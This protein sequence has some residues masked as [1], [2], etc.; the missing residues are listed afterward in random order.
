[1]L[2]YFTLLYSLSLNG[3]KTDSSSKYALLNS[4][5]SKLVNGTYDDV[6]IVISTGCSGY[7]NWQSEVLLYSW[8]KVKQP[9]RITRIAAGCKTEEDKLL[10]NK[11]AIPNDDNR[12]LWY[13]VKDYTPD[14][15]VEGVNPRD[16]PFVYL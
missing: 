3:A 8:A 14:E 6:H 13:F 15:K 4:K 1:M 5:L 11:T 9:G 12:I 16:H 7:Q 2:L 10:V